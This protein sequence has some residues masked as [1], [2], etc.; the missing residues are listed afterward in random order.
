MK[1]SIDDIVL[2]YR[3]ILNKAA[4]LKKL[5][6]LYKPTK[7][8]LVEAR[9]KHSSSLEN[10]QQREQKRCDQ[11]LE[12]VTT[13]EKEK[14]KHVN[15]SDMWCQLTASMKK[16]IRTCP[17]CYPRFY[18]DECP[19]TGYFARSSYYTEET[20]N[21]GRRLFGEHRSML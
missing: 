15:N 5:R 2:A 1:T 17:E 21:I 14:S 19:D 3:A 4:L 10:A 12:K 7:D 18:T 9:A 20:P 13:I 11:A 6:A 8:Q 16:H